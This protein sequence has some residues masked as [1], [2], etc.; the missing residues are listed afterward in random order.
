MEKANFSDM[1][2]V[3]VSGRSEAGMLL[4]YIFAALGYPVKNVDKHPQRQ[5]GA[6]YTLRQSTFNALEA[7][8][9]GLGDEIRNECRSRGTQ[10]HSP[11]SA[12]EAPGS[13]LEVGLSYP[14]WVI[15]AERL[16]ATLRS[17]LDARP[18]LGSVEFVEG[19]LTPRLENHKITWEVVQNKN[20][21]AATIDLLGAKTP[22]VVCSVEGVHGTTLESL[23]VD[24]AFITH[25]QYWIIGV[26]EGEHLGNRAELSCRTVFDGCKS[27]RLSDGRGRTAIH[28][29]IPDDQAFKL[30]QD[31]IDELF[32]G[33]VA[34]LSKLQLEDIEKWDIRGPNGLPAS[35]PRIITVQG[36]AA[37]QASFAHG[38][39]VVAG[40]GDDTS[41]SSFHSGGGINKAIAETAAVAFKLA[42]ELNGQVEP[43]KAA[44]HANKTLLDFADWF[45]YSGA[46]MFH[47][48]MHGVFV[49][50]IYAQL[51]EQW[52][53][54][55]PAP[56]FV[57]IRKK[58]RFLSQPK[59]AIMVSSASLIFPGNGSFDLKPGDGAGG[60]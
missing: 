16:H 38:E 11:I 5:T 55:K 42:A 53:K 35:K 49:Q 60:L 22:L 23:G 31:N 39:T 34:R 25:P 41:A 40:F 37:R 28:I 33:E 44:E 51:L 21:Q 9:T 24:K 57:D 14:Q 50:A 15:S 27:S 8:A 2:P 36:K 10:P 43:K 54:G 13:G 47:L 4:A 48:E 18:T 59:M 30:S 45:S 32:K 29:Q 3:I 6:V 1:P 7:I 46:T 19:M 56:D 26:V 17:A 20:S 12:D 58:L 52:H